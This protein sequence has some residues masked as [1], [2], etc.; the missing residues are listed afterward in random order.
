MVEVSALETTTTSEA[1]FTRRAV[2]GFLKGKSLLL[3]MFLASQCQTLSCP[4]GQTCSESGCVNEQVDETTLGE[5]QDTDTDLV[6]RL[7]QGTGAPPPVS[8]AGALI[9]DSGP[10]RPDAN[11]LDASTDSG[12]MIPMDAGVSEDA[13]TFPDAQV[14]V[15]TSWPVV[16]S[17]ITECRGSTP[18][19]IP[20][21][22][23]AGSAECGSTPHCGQ[24][25]Q[26][27]DPNE[28]SFVC[29]DANGQ[30]QASCPAM[31]S[32]NETVRD[33]LTG[34][35]WQRAE[36]P[37]AMLWSAA[38]DYCGNLAY[39]GQSDWRLPN[40]HELRSL[41]KLSWDP[42]R[43][44]TT[45]FPVGSEEIYWTSTRSTLVSPQEMRALVL[46]FRTGWT[47]LSD[48]ENQ[49]A[50]RCVRAGPPPISVENR[51]SET[52]TDGDVVV[53]DNLSGLQWTRTFARNLVWRQALEHCEGLDYAGQSDWRLPKRNTLAGL[54]DYGQSFP[55]TAFPGI[56]YSHPLPLSYWSSSP[57]A[58]SSGAWSVDFVYGQ[59][60]EQ[61]WNDTL[62]VR[63][64]R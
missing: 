25:A 4:E 13:S 58:S 22:G 60:Y 16:P 12:S 61:G 55:A 20:C 41:S 3:P 24:D 21:P 9:P 11:A 29:V 15:V 17:Y 7:S 52:T 10:N 26:Y 33:E 30:D 28:Q 48:M 32:A 40:A 34:L 47:L 44:D 43:I 27:P 2:T 39:G 63:C 18:N 59:N 31:V 64:V 19:V 42:Q 1:L 38:S 56:R 45:A 6:I 37:G 50:V 23:T 14:G 8:D 49:N 36:L 62:F 51:F 57:R 35:V 46:N 53:S 5:A 54:L